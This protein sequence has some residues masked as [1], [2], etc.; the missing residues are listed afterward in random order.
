M[1]TNE[2]KMI[3]KNCKTEKTITVED[4]PAY[5]GTLNGD[6]FFIPPLQCT[7]CFSEIQ[8][9]G[10]IVNEDTTKK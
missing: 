3:C 4:V 2:I 10:T 6:F 8:L 7:E 1:K 5:G 9:E